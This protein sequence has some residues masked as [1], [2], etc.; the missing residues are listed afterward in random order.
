MAI[1]SIKYLTKTFSINN[2]QLVVIPS[3]ERLFAKEKK[4]TKL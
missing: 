4:Y 2:K 1:F 3:P